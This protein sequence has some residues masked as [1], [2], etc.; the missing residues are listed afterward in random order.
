MPKPQDLSGIEL[1]DELLELREAI[2]AN[3]H[4]VWTQTRKLE[5][6]TYGPNRDDEN[7]LHPDLVPYYMLPESEKKYDRQMAISTI[8]LVKKLGWNIVKRED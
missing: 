6:W 1:E 5:G 4:E 2:A 7:K 3:A 8:K